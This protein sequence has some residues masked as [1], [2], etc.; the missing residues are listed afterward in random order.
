MKEVGFKPILQVMDTE[1]S[2]YLQ[3]KKTFSGEK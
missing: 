3:S 1:D 2:V